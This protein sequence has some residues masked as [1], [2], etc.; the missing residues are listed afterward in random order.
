MKLNLKKIKKYVKKELHS[1][2]RRHTPVFEFNG[3]GKAK[4]LTAKLQDTSI[5]GYSVLLD[6]MI[7]ADGEFLFDAM[8]DDLEV[9]VETATEAFSAMDDTY[10]RVSIDEF[11]SINSSGYCL[12]EKDI[13]F[14]IKKYLTELVTLTKENEHIQALIADMEQE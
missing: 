10:L 8:Y 3:T 4:S 13:R 14:L 2:F 5:C 7:F 1:K 11:L 6:F 9:T 12:R